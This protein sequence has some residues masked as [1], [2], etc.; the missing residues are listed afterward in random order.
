M[1]RGAK[2]RTK[3]DVGLEAAIKAICAASEIPDLAQRKQ[4][5][6]VEIQA[7]W[8]NVLCPTLETAM[9]DKI[10]ETLQKRAADF[11]LDPKDIATLLEEEN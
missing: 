3:L 7:L 4:Q 1:A 8:R 2:K 11:G 9:D 6:L 5:V 10:R